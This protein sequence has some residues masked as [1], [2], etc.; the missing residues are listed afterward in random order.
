MI[1]T[2]SDT[3]DCG[4]SSTEVVASYLG[5]LST[6]GKFTGSSYWVSDTDKL[7]CDSFQLICTLPVTK[8][9]MLGNERK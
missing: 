3:P 5:L 2:H 8:Q 4:L 6:H 9:G 1:S 7:S